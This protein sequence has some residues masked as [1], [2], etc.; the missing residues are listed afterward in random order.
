[1]APDGGMRVPF[2]FSLS[3]WGTV[4]MGHLFQVGIFVVRAW[5]PILPSCTEEEEGLAVSFRIL[6]AP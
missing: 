2:L 5:I 4:V 1:M 3:S 6:E